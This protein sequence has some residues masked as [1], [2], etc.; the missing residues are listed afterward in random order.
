MEFNC[1]FPLYFYVQS[2]FVHVLSC[3]SLLFHVQIYSIST[4]DF[5]IHFVYMVKISFYQ[6]GHPIDL[7]LLYKQHKNFNSHSYKELST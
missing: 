3:K 5:C 7:A 2:I 4:S 6:Y 1:F